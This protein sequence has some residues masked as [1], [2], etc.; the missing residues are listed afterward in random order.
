MLCFFN[1]FAMFLKVKGLAEDDA[2]GDEDQLLTSSI[3]VNV[4]QILQNLTL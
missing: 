1:V 4:D 2:A 3:D